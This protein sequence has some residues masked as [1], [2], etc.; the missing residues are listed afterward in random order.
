MLFVQEILAPNT[1]VS[2]QSGL[3]GGYDLGRGHAVLQFLDGFDAAKER[4]GFGD[5]KVLRIQFL[6]QGSDLQAHAHGAHLGA[7]SDA[8]A[9]PSAAPSGVKAADRDEVL[10]DEFQSGKMYGIESGRD[11]FAVHPGSAELFERGFGAA[12]DRDSGVLENL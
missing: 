10:R 3:P 6:E 12:A 9:H 8:N 5:I 11:F 2:G 1:V 4:D 7:V